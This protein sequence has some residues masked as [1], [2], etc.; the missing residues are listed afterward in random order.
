MGSTVSSYSTAKRLE[1]GSPGGGAGG[2]KKKGQDPEADMRRALADRIEDNLNGLLG[3]VQEIIAENRQQVLSLAHALET[4]KTL[5]G[6]DVIAVIERTQGPFVDGRA[7]ADP[8]LTRQLEEYHLGAAA[9]HREH[10]KIVLRMPEVPRT[11]VLAASGATGWLVAPDP[12]P[13]DIR[14]RGNGA[15]PEDTPGPGGG[16]GAPATLTQDNGSESLPGTAAPAGH[17]PDNPGLVQRAVTQARA[18]SGPLPPPEILGEYERQL[19]GAVKRILTFDMR[20]TIAMISISGV[21]F[22]VAIASV[23]N[24]VAAII[25]GSTFLAVP[26]IIRFRAFITRR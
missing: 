12:D 5:T 18:W 2:R 19:P 23:G 13:L 22:L 9:A 4:H 24:T 3:R 1:V 8:G 11:P 17:T 21:F 25:G 15:E 7:Y 26:V 6:E 10:G 20:L 16:R 14:D